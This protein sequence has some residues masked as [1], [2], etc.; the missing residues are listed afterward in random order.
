MI[1]RQRAGPNS[2]NDRLIVSSG[3]PLVLSPQYPGRKC[4]HF[5][6]DYDST[7]N[8]FRRSFSNISVRSRS[9]VK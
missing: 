2:E 7:R 5:V 3:R 8:S 9:I 6:A 1:P 4:R